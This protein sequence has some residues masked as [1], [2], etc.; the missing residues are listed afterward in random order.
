[1]EK[2]DDEIINPA[3]MLA[4]SR[5][6]ENNNLITQNK[7]IGE[8]LKARFLVPFD[9][10]FKEGTETEKVRNSSNTNMAFNLV[11]TTNDE[12]YFIAFTDMGEL[13]KWRD[14]DKQNVMI[15]SFDEVAGLVQRAKEKTAGF[16]LNPATT[17]VTFRKNIIDNIMISRNK[18]MEQEKIKAKSEQGVALAETEASSKKGDA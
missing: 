13:K 11:K 12:I 9:M 4:I 5:M 18:A 7:M 10:Q 14:N 8:A 15:M 17:N 6:K 3:L 1:M 16:V 2:V